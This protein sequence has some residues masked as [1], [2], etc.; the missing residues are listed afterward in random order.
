MPR[1]RWP[2]ATLMECLSPHQ[3]GR[4]W[5]SKYLTVLE[6]YMARQLASETMAILCGWQLPEV[7]QS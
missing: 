7:R 5:L 6:G 1:S 4:A 2:K 3:L